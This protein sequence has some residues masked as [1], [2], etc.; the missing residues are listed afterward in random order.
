MFIILYIWQLPQ[1]LI[2]LF[3]LIFSEKIEFNKSNVFYSCT[4]INSG[5][6]L[7]NYIFLPNNAIYNDL[8]LKHEIGHS[9]QSKYLGWFYLIVIGM[10]SLANN[11][12]SRFNKEYAK[13]YYNKF[14]EN[15]ADKLGGVKRS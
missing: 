7:G 4:V 15:W 5:L 10:P 13:N 3:F 12:V 9:I 6:S 14:P 11:I 1:H 2:A 8:L